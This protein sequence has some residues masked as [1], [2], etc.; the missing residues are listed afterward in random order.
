LNLI[1]SFLEISQDLIKSRNWEKDTVMG[2]ATLLI[3]TCNF[4]LL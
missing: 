2:V 4:R 1:Y 3:N